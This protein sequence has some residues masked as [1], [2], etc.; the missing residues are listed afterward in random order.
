MQLKHS[1]KRHINC[2]KFDCTLSSNKGK[3]HI[4]DSI[5]GVFPWVLNRA[6]KIQYH[7]PHN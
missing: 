4:Y 1:R 6:E 3:I 5:K 2:Q 7:T